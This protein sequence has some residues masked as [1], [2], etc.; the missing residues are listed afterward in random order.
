MK[1][2]IEKISPDEALMILKQLSKTDKRIKKK[3]E[4]ISATDVPV[5]CFSNLLSPEDENP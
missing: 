2:L 1:P 4:E 3:I 5:E